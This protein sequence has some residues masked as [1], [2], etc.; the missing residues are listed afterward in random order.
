M[1]LPATIFAI[2]FGIGLL[3][4]VVAL[5]SS[6]TRDAGKALDPLVGADEISAGILIFIALLWPL[7]LFA[8]L[9]KDEDKRL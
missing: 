1:S 9:T 4:M 7:W 6:K 2:Y 5:V 3:L 8:A